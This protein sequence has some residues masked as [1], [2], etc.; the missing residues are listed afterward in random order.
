MKKIQNGG[1]I[2]HLPR[3]GFGKKADL[4]AEKTLNHLGRC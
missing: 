2:E 1:N 4:E 3:L